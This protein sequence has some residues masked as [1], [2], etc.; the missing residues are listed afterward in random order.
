MT[1]D[2]QQKLPE[3]LAASGLATLFCAQPH[4][5]PGFEEW[6]RE[7]GYLRDGEVLPDREF[8]CESSRVLALL[9]SQ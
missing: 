9:I 6:L 2:A 8:L 4:V 5:W 1:T 3:V 7:N